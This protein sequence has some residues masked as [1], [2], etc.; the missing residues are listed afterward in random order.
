MDFPLQDEDTEPIAMNTMG[1]LISANS[2]AV[3]IASTIDF[4]NDQL[5]QVCVI[6]R[7]CIM[8]ITVL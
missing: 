6:P 3:V 4:E 7:G 1:Y 2:K 5:S 8:S